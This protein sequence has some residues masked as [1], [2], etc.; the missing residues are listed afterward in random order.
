MSGNS[1]SCLKGFKEP[2]EAKE[3]MWDFSGDAT[4]EK[5]LISRGVE[6]LLIF[7]ELQQEVGVTLELRWGAQGTA[8]RATGTA[9]LHESCEGHL[10]IPLQ[11]LPG[12]TST[13]GVEA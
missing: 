11:S 3:G 4:V 10:G 13:S 2:F 12:P 9:S 8:S 5:G 7:L 6:N 1:L